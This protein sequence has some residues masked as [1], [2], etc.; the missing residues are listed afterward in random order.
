M[1]SLL[2][3]FSSL[4]AVAAAVTVTRAPMT[5]PTYDVGKPD[6]NPMFFEKRV[7]QGACGKV[8]PVPFIDK[9]Y[10]EKHD[11]S[12]DAITVENDYTRVVLLP[13]LGGR[14]YIGQDKT[15]GDYDFFY[16]NA[17]IKPAL[18]GLAGP[19]LSGGV[20][21]NW[22]QHHRPATFMP[23][24]ATIE[25]GDDGSVTVWMA[26]H[27][28]LNRLEGRHGICM[29]PGSS[30]VELK[31][32]LYNRTPFT[33]TFHWWA[34]VAAKVHD[35]YESFF[36]PDV[37][38]VA[39]HAGRAKSSFPIAQNLYY[40]VDYRARPGAN[41]L[42]WYKN[43]PVP[44]SYMVCATDYDFFG[45]YDHAANGGF[46]H[47]ADRHIAPGKKQWTWGNH[48]FGYAWDR[49]LTDDSGPYIELMA[50]VYTDNQPDF[51]YLLPYE[52]KT[53]SQYWW[54]YKNLGPVKNANT[55]LAV[56]LGN[57]KAGVV[58]SE[59]IDGVEIVLGRDASRRVQKADLRVGHPVVFDTDADFI[60]V[61]KGDETLIAFDAKGKARE[62]PVNQ[63]WAD[64]Q[65]RVP[66]RDVATEPPAP[67]D[68]ASAD[69]LF[70]TAEHL[71]QYRH[72]TRMPEAYLDE[73]L[74]RDPEDSR[75][76][77]LYGKRLIY[78]GLLAEAEA[79]L[80]RAVKRQTRRHPNPYTGES[81]Y[82]LGLARQLQGRIDSAYPC[83]YKATW[84]YE[85]RSAGYYRL[86]TI[87]AA[88]GDWD[89]AKEHAA[90]SL[91][92]DARNEKARQLLAI[93][94]GGAASCRAI[95]Q[96]PEMAID[97]A[98]DL[99][100]MGQ[101]DKAVELLKK[102]ELNTLGKY[103]LAYLAKDKSLL[104]EAAKSSADYFFPSR[105]DDYLALV[106]CDKAAD[107]R[108]ANVAYALGNWCY[109]R[110]RHEE[111]LRYWNR[112]TELAPEF[113]TAWRNLGVSLW[114]VRRDGKGAMAAYERAIKNDPK[115]ARLVAEFDQLREKCK[116]PVAKRL[117]FLEAHRELVLSRDDA[118]IQYATCLNDLDRQKDALSVISAHRFHPWEGGEGKVLKQYTR[119]HLELGF[120]ALERGEFAEALERAEKSFA[121]PQNLGE[122]YHLLQAK[123]DVNYLKGMALKGLGRADEAKKAFESCAAEA[124]DFLSMAVTE[125]SELSY[126]RGLA[127]A[128]LGRKD[129][130][131]RL[132]EGMLAFAEKGLKTPFK[133]DYF[134]TSLPLL[135]IFEDDLEAVKNAQ[136][137]R[138]RSLALKGTK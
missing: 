135:L 108:D 10:D 40:G 76:H 18:V 119:A 82:Y 8:Y 79:H 5:I 73:L 118:T 133:I 23:T 67:K 66:P 28:P 31:A 103:V 94:Q 114:N 95:N 61:K 97:Y 134:A 35:K 129:D 105:L 71:D 17:V 130:A 131:K 63:A 106:W 38:Y 52:T 117:A 6:R 26:D 12:Y 115:D 51:T 88:R 91:V 57:G 87:D 72:P 30:V 126:Y 59:N 69:E 46:V 42:Q 9:V 58:A 98:Y 136:M 111:A 16:R 125:Y 92:T 110:K 83:F 49:E 60:A 33:Q 29:R 75:A 124:G 112:A 80:V 113:P 77:T 1:K 32:V 54:P 36:P 102:R 122:A 62:Q 78:R 22:P 25:K 81:L 107:G 44:T 47:I 96:D 109:D 34:N 99:A 64:A 41:D 14:I 53:F 93:A 45:G 138:L 20:E 7:Y 120:K 48:P 2:L 101:T 68:I 86:A 50:G 19:W 3:F 123:A 56:S 11:K 137:E 100:E 85:F 116:V 24:E 4:P 70:I 39:D 84:N 37:D 65:E 43:I 132:F 104:A 127:L 21:F 55:K 27:D 74:R 90:E 15:N 121:T 128:E 13:E 89:K